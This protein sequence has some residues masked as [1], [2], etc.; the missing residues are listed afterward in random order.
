MLCFRA[1]TT[2][3]RSHS[4]SRSLYYIQQYVHVVDFWACW[5]SGRVHTT[6]ATKINRGAGS[7]HM[8]SSSAPHNTEIGATLTHPDHFLF[9]ECLVTRMSG[10]T[11]SCVH[12]CCAQRQL[13]SRLF[14][15]GAV[16][17]VQ[18]Y[19]THS[20]HTRQQHQCGCCFVVAV[21]TPLQPARYDFLQWS[22][23]TFH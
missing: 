22:Q 12:S 23:A 4:L 13:F 7:S 14:S 21:F 5:A 15:A 9:S 10:K 8:N 6:L 17:T 19:D 11:I 1:P 18:Q 20:V 2:A 3:I 16:H